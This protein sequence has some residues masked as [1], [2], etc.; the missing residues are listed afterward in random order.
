MRHW[1]NPCLT[2]TPPNAH[3]FPSLPK[4]WPA[5]HAYRESEAG[6]AEIYDIS[7]GVVRIHGLHGPAVRVC[8]EQKDTKKKE[9]REIG[10]AAPQHR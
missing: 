7:A 3:H 2:P 9:A 10:T 4:R 5:M 8:D 6:G 1:P